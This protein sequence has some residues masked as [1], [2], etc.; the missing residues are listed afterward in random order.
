MYNPENLAD[1]ELIRMNKFLKKHPECQKKWFVEQG[2]CSN[3]GYDIIRLETQFE[4]AERLSKTQKALERRNKCKHAQKIRD[5]VKK[6]K[7]RN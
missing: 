7:A 6:I 1:K 2:P 3:W 4:V 5:L